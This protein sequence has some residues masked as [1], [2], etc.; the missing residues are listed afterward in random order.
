MHIS[1]I[2]EAQHGRYLQS[3]VLCLPYV[4]NRAKMKFHVEKS[5]KN[6]TSIQQK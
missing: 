6:K 1:Q 4:C 2:D 5:N 3:D